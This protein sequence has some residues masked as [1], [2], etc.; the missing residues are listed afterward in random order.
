V[1]EGV[2]SKCCLR[3]FISCFGFYVWGMGREEYAG[4]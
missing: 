3:T 1:L 4:G 2:S